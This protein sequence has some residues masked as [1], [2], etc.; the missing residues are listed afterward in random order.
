MPHA[1]FLHSRS[2]FQW[3]A[4]RI[5][6]VMSRETS[7]AQLGTAAEIF[8]R[9]AGTGASPVSTAQVAGVRLIGGQAEVADRPPDTHGNEHNCWYKTDTGRVW[10]VTRGAHAIYGV[11]ADAAAYLRRW[12]HSNEFFEDEIRLEGI[13]PD[14]RFVISQ[15]FLQGEVP[16]TP[17]LHADLLGMGW[18]QYRNSGTVWT[19]P[20]GRIVMSEV[21]NGNF[22]K[23]PDGTISAIDVAL[24][25]REE[26]DALL[27]PEEFA[28]AFGQ[29]HRPQTL[30]ELMKKVD[31]DLGAFGFAPHLARE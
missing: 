9:Y 15:P 12:L 16:S 2:Q 20:D 7:L 1:E 11:S 28:E 25:S 10:K 21:H 31:R 6:S 27:E 17:E 24:H 19:S 14:G 3:A 29:D 22:I 26:W 30:S 5:Q 8:A 23:Q 13:L 18:I 4:V